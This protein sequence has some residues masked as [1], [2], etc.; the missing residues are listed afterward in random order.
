M[1]INA[2]FA[3]KSAGHDR[4]VKMTSAVLCTLVTGVQLT[5]IFEEQFGGLERIFQ[6]LADLLFP[7]TRQGSTRLKGFT[8][9]LS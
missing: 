1:A 7:I 5:L 4:D 3:V 9:T 6:A 2:A 8:T